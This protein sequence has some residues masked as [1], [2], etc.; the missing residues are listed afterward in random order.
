[1]YTGIFD[2]SEGWRD[3]STFKTREE[4]VEWFESHGINLTDGPDVDDWWNP[5]PLIIGGESHTEETF[6]H[7][8]YRYC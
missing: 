3:I 5:S 1:M 7:L 8:G 4:V 2:D 6:E